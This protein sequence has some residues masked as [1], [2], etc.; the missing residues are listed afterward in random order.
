M[1]EFIISQF[2][3]SCFLLYALSF[4]FLAH[5]RNR[6]L[7]IKK[8]AA[9]IRARAQYKIQKSKLQKLVIP[10][11][12]RNAVIFPAFI[13][14]CFIQIQLRLAFKLSNFPLSLSNFN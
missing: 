9:A 10:H 4:L 1:S 7:K 3:R 11:V 2:V 6:G 14:P 5:G 13:S 12:K 8:D